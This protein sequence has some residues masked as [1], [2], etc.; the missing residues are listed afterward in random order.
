VA[1]AG[2]LLG[3]AWAAYLLVWFDQHGT[4]GQARASVWWCMPGMTVAPGGGSSVSASAASGL[5]GWLL[6]SVAMTVGGALPAAQYVAV[7]SFRRRRSSSVLLFLFVDL[8]LWASVGLPVLSV[9][10]A[11][12]WR[13][14]LVLASVTLAIAAGY[15]LTSAKRASVNRCHRTIR[16]P[17]STRSGLVA[18]GR[19][20]WVNTSGC[21]GACLPAM[22]VMF[23]F[24]AAQPVAMVVLTATTT[25]GRLARRPGRARRRLAGVYSLAAVAV[26]AA[27]I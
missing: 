9:F 3:A 5:P 13:P 18:V 27:A 24:G 1:A 10:A 12:G 14:S 25:Y 11:V 2:W 17:A 7:N 4:T 19:F 15:E 21:I 23:A 20:A 8:L 16:L 22:F 26:L 6:M